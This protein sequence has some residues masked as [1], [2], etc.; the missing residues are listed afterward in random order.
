M[1]AICTLRLV[2]LHGRSKSGS[3]R[4][5]FKREADVISIELESVRKSAAGMVFVAKF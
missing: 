1:F 4:Q 3:Q 2:E 5:I